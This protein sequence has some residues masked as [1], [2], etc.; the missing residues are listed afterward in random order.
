MAASEEDLV[1]QAVGRLLADHDPQATEAPA[2]WGAR[3]DAGLAWVGFPSGSGGRGVHPGLQVL[4]DDLLAEAAAPENWYRNPVGLGAVAA[5]LVAHGTEDQRRRWLRRIFTCEDVWC[6]L[7]TEPGAGSDLAGLAST[8]RPDG[9]DGEAW[10]VSGHKR[11]STLAHVARWGLLLA[12]SHPDRPRHRGLTCFA[13]DL[14]SAGVEIRPTRQMDGDAEFAEVRLEGV[15]VPDADRVG[16]PGGGWEVAVT[17]LDHERLALAGPH[18]RQGSGPVAEALRLWR[19]GP[20]SDPVLRDHLAGA[21]IDAEAARLTTARLRATQGPDGPGAVGAV[22]KLLTAEVD[23]RVWE[24]CVELLGP[25]GALYD[26]WETG[27]PRSAGE[28]RR[29]V[30]RAFLR[31]RALTIQGGT[32]E[33]VRTM[34]AERV[35]GLPPEPGPATPPGP[36]S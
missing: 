16:D 1:R 12:R 32:A 35:L 2:F 14:R 26:T 18:R 29:D 6:Q 30:R 7:W 17:T 24:L 11:F 28:S 33:V 27:V 13:V 10:V 34:L 15:R 5:A 36:T 3:F 21:W 20:G 22:A 31:S 8:A 23:Q 4:V 9:D 19:Q 25:A